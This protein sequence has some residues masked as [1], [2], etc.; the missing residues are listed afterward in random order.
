MVTADF[1]TTEVE[2]ASRGLDGAA[3]RADFPILDQANEWGQELV[4]LDSAASSQKPAAVLEALDDYHRH[5]NANIHRGMYAL[6]ERATAR[7]EAARQRVAEFIGATSP[8][9]CI[10]VRNTTEAINLVA[11]SWGRRNVSAGD[12]IVLT[13]ME[14]HSNLVPWQLLA[15]ERG[16]GLA[17]VQMDAEGRLDLDHLDTLLARQPKLMAFTHVSNALGTVNDAAEIVRRAHAAGAVVLIDGAQSVPHLPVDV[18]A[19]DCDFL[20]FSGHKMLGP[21]GSGVLYGKLALLEAMPPFLAGGGMIGRVGLER[22]TWAEAPAKF[23]AGTPAVADA[24]GLGAAVEYLDGLGM[25]QVQAHVRDLTAY[26]IGRLGEV[27]GVTIYGPSGAGQRSGVVPFTVAGMPAHEVAAALDGENVAIRAGH[28]CC[29]PLL[30]ALGVGAIARA[31]FYVYNA[32]EDVDRLIAALERAIQALGDPV[33]ALPADDGGGACRDRWQ[34][35]KPIAGEV[36]REERT[37][38]LGA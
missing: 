18:R 20:A 21:M 5:Y 33:A 28:H 8:R 22:S 26:A 32:E 3:I 19:L 2:R 27:P 7:Y 29:Q 30:R 11:H 24:I 12:L 15:E 10:F 34:G 37:A 36:R 38:R 23:E 35:L 6:S 17:H 13:V 1:S 4:F 31:S 16:A 14:H 25:E 9:E